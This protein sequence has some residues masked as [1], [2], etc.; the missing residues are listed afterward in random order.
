MLHR[1]IAV[2]GSPGKENAERVFRSASGHWW[3][4]RDSLSISFET[5]WTMPSSCIQDAERVI[6]P[7][8]RTNP[9]AGSLRSFHSNAFSRSMSLYRAGLR[10]ALFLP[11]GVAIPSAAFPLYGCRVRRCEPRFHSALTSRGDYLTNRT[12]V[13][14]RYTVGTTCLATSFCSH[15]GA[16]DGQATPMPVT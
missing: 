12:R 10:L 2:H 11:L 8:F 16:T 9:S 4:R 13:R 3:R 5:G 1:A 6:R 7:C 14:K 15:S